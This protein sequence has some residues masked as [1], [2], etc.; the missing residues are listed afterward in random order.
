MG[1]YAEGVLDHP[2]RLSRRALLT[3]GGAVAGIGVAG[4]LTVQTE[5]LPGRSWLYG[6]LGL[7]GEDG[8]VPDIAGGR[9]EHG[10]FVSQARLG[11]VCRWALALPPGSALDDGLPVVL[12]LHGHGHDHSAAFAPDRLALDRFLADAVASG[13]APYA[14]ASVDGG[15]SYWHARDTG[16]D[17]G[18]MVVDEFLPL[19][20][21]RGLDTD[22][23][24][25]LGWSMGGFGALHL[26]P[27]VPRLRGVSVMSPALWHEFGDTRP[28]AYDDEDDFAEVT[29]FGREA[30][31]TDIPL[32]V[33]CGEGDPFYAATRDFVDLLDPRPAG[34]FT[35][36]DHDLGYWRRVVPDQLAFLAERF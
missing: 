7:D 30:S 5:L 20:T 28:G 13:T 15:D 1:P 9:V 18:T 12:T 8:K 29:V 36:G 31:L 11:A 10:E 19:L 26:A 22:R 17:A 35:L 33:D 24:A 27:R 25:L 3:G 6:R 14:I 16:E 21:E 2:R 32:R 34:G 4:A 23:V